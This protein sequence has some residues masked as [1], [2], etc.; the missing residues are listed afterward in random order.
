MPKH[1]S[2]SGIVDAPEYVELI[3]L[4][5]QQ[6]MARPTFIRLHRNDRNAGL[7]CYLFAV[8]LDRCMGN[9]NTLNDLSNNVIV[10][11]KTEYLNLSVLNM[12][13]GKN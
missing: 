5:N 7:C 2:F 3:S 1:K 9:C 11:K 10:P 4:N 12:I 8:N 13:A 6:C